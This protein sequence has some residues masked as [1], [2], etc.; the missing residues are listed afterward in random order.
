MGARFGVT[1][2]RPSRRQTFEE[3]QDAPAVVRVIPSLARSS[4]IRFRNTFQP[5]CPHTLSIGPKAPGGVP[6]GHRRRGLVSPYPTT[7]KP[8]AP[9]ALSLGVPVSGPRGPESQRPSPQSPT[10]HPHRSSPIGARSLSPIPARAC[11]DTE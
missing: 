9:P 7:G 3:G 6:V 8:D 10:S 4:G 1:P 2:E 5:A 11:P